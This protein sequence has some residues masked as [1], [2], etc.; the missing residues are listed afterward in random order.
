MFER[1]AGLRHSPLARISGCVPYEAGASRFSQMKAL[2][3]YSFRITAARLVAMFAKGMSCADLRLPDLDCPAPIE[4][5]AAVQ[6]LQLYNDSAT[7]LKLDFTPARLTDR[8]FG[9]EQSRD[10]QLVDDKVRSA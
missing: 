9:D 1:S 5:A 8:L 3:Q 7:R 10:R 4:L 2:F 6:R